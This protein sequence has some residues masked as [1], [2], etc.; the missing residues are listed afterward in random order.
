MK[1]VDLSRYGL[2]LNV[3]RHLHTQ[4]ERV[5]VFAYSE[6]PISPVV[7]QKLESVGFQQNNEGRWYGSPDLITPALLES[8][9]PRMSIVEL[10][11]EARQ[12]LVSVIDTRKK[13]ADNSISIAPGLTINDATISNS[14]TLNGR[15]DQDKKDATL[16][17]SSENYVSD[18]RTQSDER[19][20]IPN[21]QE[22]NDNEHSSLQNQDQSSRRDD[23][24]GNRDLPADE[25]DRPDVDA[26][27]EGGLRESLSGNVDPGASE[28]S[29]NDEGSRAAGSKIRDDRQ[30][31]KPISDGKN[32]LSGNPASS[33][34]GGVSEQRGNDG[35]SNELSDLDG[36]R[37]DGNRESVESDG[38]QSLESEKPKKVKE[39][40]VLN[41]DHFDL[42]AHVA[43]SEASLDDGF[44]PKSRFKANIEAIQTLYEVSVS[45]GIATGEER[46]KLADY[47]SWG[48]LSDAFSNQYAWRDQHAQLENLVES[49][50]LSQQDLASFQDATLNAHYTP[51]LVL[52]Y[53]WEGIQRLGF[54][55]GKMLEPCV[56]TGNF[57]G[58]M[59]RDLVGNT[60]ITATEIEK[61]SASIAKLLYPNADIK[62]TP[63]EKFPIEDGTYDLVATNVPFGDYALH[64]PK[65][66][67]YR[68]SIHNYF[69]LRSLDAVRGNGITALITSTYTLD[70]KTSSARK[71]MAE[72]G[73]LLGAIRL[74][75]NTFKNTA[76]TTVATDILFFRRFTSDEARQLMQSQLNDD[77][78][79]WPTWVHGK[80]FEDNPSMVLGELKEAYSRFGGWEWVPVLEDMSTLPELLE[81][82]I[83]KL[84]EGVFKQRPKDDEKFD[85]SR[86]QSVSFV[87]FESRKYRVGGFILADQG[88]GLLEPSVV[89]SVNH[90]TGDI[91]VELYTG[92]QGKSRERLIDLIEIRDKVLRVLDL[93][94]SNNTDTPEY[95]SERDALNALYDQFVADHGYINSPANARLFRSDPQAGLAFAIENYDKET[96]SATKKNIFNERIIQIQATPKVETPFDALAV[97]MS[98]IGRPSRPRIMSLLDLP[99]TDE[100]WDKVYDTIKDRIFVSPG[101]ESLISSDVY[102]SGN[103]RYKL[104]QA[105]T[106]AANDDRFN[107]NVE[108]LKEVMPRDL[109][110]SDINV[111]MGA[112]WIPASDV[113]KF[114]CNLLGVSQEQIKV[115]HIPELNNWKIE[116]HTS[117]KYDY[118]F[119]LNN[120]TAWGTESMPAVKL[121]EMALQKQVP[122]VW[123]EVDIGGGDTKRVVDRDKTLAAQ[124]KQAEIETRFQSWIW[125]DDERAERLLADY[126][127]RFNCFVA[128]EPDGSHLTF[129]G[130][131]P[132]IS[133]RPHQKNAVWRGL[134]TP[135]TLLA[136]EVGTGK[137]FTMIASLMEK[138]RLGQAQRPFMVVRRNTIGQI[139][140]A[141]RDLYPG[142]DVLVMDAQS[143]TKS[144]RREFLARV[145]AS[146]FD[147]AIMSYESFAAMPLSPE[148]EARYLN[149]R[150]S[151]YKDILLQQSIEN[152]KSYSVKQLTKMVKTMEAKIQRILSNEKKDEAIYFDEVYP[153]A[154][155]FDESHMLKNLDVASRYQEFSSEGSKRAQDAFAKMMWLYREKGKDCNTLFAS[156]TPI[157]NTFAESL[158]LM[159]YMM[160]SDFE[161]IM[162]SMNPDRFFANFM[163]RYVTPEIG[164]DG[165]YKLRSRYSVV[166]IP[167]LM[168]MMGQFMDVRYADDIGIERPD[169]ERTIIAAKPTE[170]QDIYRLE[171][172]R[173][174]DRIRSGAVDRSD[175]NY[176]KIASDGRKAALDMRLVDPD[177]PDM[178]GTKLNVMIDEIVKRYDS[179]SSFKG[180]QAVFCDQGVPGGS[181]FDLY[182]DIKQKLIARGVDLA[183]I[184]FAHD[185]KTDDAREALFE[186]V[187]K[188]VI[189]IIIG[190]TEK[191]GTGTNMQERLCA[192]HHLDAPSNMRPSDVEQREGRIERQGNMNAEAEILTYTSEDSFDLFVWNLMNFKRKMVRQI[193]KNDASIREFKEDEEGAS[194]EAIM[195]VTTGNTLIKEKIEV[196]Q[197]VDVL[198]AKQREHSNAQRSRRHEAINA[199]SLMNESSRKISALERMLTFRQE[200][201]VQ[202]EMGLE[203][204]NQ[205][206]TESQE[207]AIDL[208]HQEQSA[209]TEKK[210]T[211]SEFG[212]WVVNGKP[213]LRSKEADFKKALRSQASLEIKEFVIQWKSELEMTYKGFQIN[214]NFMRVTDWDGY[215][216]AEEVVAK[217]PDSDSRDTLSGK[218]LYKVLDAI[219]GL[220]ESIK[221]EKENLVYHEDVKRSALVEAEKPFTLE[222]ELSSLKTKQMVLANELEESAKAFQEALRSSGAITSIQAWKE[223]HLVINYEKYDLND[224]NDLLS[225]DSENSELDN[226]LSVSP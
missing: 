202:R 200:W 15:Q 174:A 95:L 50:V 153:D 105:E 22:G 139:E 13:N 141:I 203:S 54:D 45:D 164:V 83:K 115:S 53:L 179:T 14:S 142:A 206:A 9:F 123:K 36:S 194:Y 56:A 218:Q 217:I 114:V 59:P 220:E 177:L 181:G 191:M 104:V 119:K 31:E 10:D 192:L 71:R 176:L 18:S 122:T 178:P 106:A 73:E 169:M 158:T 33:E 162:G 86:V 82:A 224:L 94:R 93:Q 96:N 52:K 30:A 60:R 129:P 226:T 121:I 51:P 144:N 67:K 27:M 64:D 78:F 197:K 208:N 102:L 44:K 207:G 66:D 151:E 193:M 16:A 152:E 99:D 138:K 55:G 168:G 219:D 131:S 19:T 198:S 81:N 124:S 180:T 88:D 70:S 62:I 34:L 76:G 175:D 201:D 170:L 12:R 223:Q 29:P 171:I 120:L 72:R 196:D 109:T 91:E 100:E 127:Q 145:A 132:L 212:G 166:N 84:P 3:L 116:P 25:L 65:Y 135:N 140:T 190:S 125:E 143:M 173:R 58:T 80:Y 156:G 43:N 148:E 48:G 17:E 74:P 210:H 195:A 28:G 89:K 107:I 130:M 2:Q 42:L 20:R 97:C 189:R 157:S 133:L 68:L 26:E 111:Q 167:E 118:S 147:I 184:A 188:G 4:G 154:L 163:S 6:R 41:E 187:N 214:L 199:E 37:T 160:P 79:N 213:I 221:D 77:E 24:S 150:L 38:N 61:T 183:T 146:S 204:E 103:V 92:A 8:A 47:V 225:I 39:A 186:Q 69:I 205:A 128:M 75:N 23:T 98:D 90:D 85:E 136:H 182:N 63:F 112:P 165:Q 211:L 7:A 110:P 185:A 11:D 46:K 159:R 134:T 49:G 1:W 161:R 21:T 172:A 108:K 149:D 215:H 113:S 216:I 117:I 222:A 126:N 101:D 57:L 209:A 40:Q 137:T 155:C 32:G 35:D 5:I 87:D